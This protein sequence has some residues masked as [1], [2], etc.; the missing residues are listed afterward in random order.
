MLFFLRSAACVSS[1]EPRGISSIQTESVSDLNNTHIASLPDRLEEPDQPAGQRRAEN[2][3]LDLLY[4]EG[5][6]GFRWG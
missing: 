4:D 5:R 1:W 3:V 6:E 2:S